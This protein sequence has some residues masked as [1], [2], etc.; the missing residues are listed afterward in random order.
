MSEVNKQEIAALREFNR[1]YTGRLGVLNEGLLDS[2][3]SLAEVRVM[4]E[5]DAHG[6]S[7]RA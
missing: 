7:G 5:L 4:Y 3:F 6:P 1:F 2:P